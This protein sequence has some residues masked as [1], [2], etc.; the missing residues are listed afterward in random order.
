M[1][2]VTAFER[3]MWPAM[4]ARVRAML[5]TPAGKIRGRRPARRR[6]MRQQIEAA[7]P[8]QAIAKPAK[9]RKLLVTDIQMYSGH[10]T[11]PHG[12]YLLELMGKQTGA[13]EPIFSNDLGAAEVSQ[14]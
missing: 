2:N 8:R 9:P 5:D 3:V 6:T 7:A 11:I 14:G 10:S 1:K 4:A 12:T 13:F